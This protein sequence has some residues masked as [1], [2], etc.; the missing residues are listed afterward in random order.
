MESDLRV[1]LHF[2]SVVLAAYS[3]FILCTEKNRRNKDKSILFLASLEG[4]VFLL[5]GLLGDGWM[6]WVFV[7]IYTVVVVLH[8]RSLRQR[9]NTNNTNFP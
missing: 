6:S 4:C 2:V 8:L 5:L 7:V 9:D 1:L 3:L